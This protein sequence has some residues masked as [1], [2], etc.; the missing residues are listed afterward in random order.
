LCS[1][2]KDSLLAIRWR[3]GGSGQNGGSLADSQ[4]P[5]AVSK[6]PNADIVGRLAATTKSILS[7][8]R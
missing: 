4:L 5:T 1:W 2:D 7:I 6:R 8:I 3:Q